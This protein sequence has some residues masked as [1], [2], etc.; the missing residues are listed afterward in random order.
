MCSTGE[1]PNTDNHSYI[2]IGC[3]YSFIRPSAKTITHVTFEI[4]HQQ[5]FDNYYIFFVVWCDFIQV[6]RYYIVLIKALFVDNK[7]KLTKNSKNMQK[8]T[9]LAEKRRK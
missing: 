9:K 7:S 6:E 5:W 3:F 1:F 8:L 2:P 4:Y